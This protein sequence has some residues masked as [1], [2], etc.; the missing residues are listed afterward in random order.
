MGI[1][2]STTW[3]KNWE[4]NSV[5]SQILS[6]GLWYSICMWVFHQKSEKSTIPHHLWKPHPHPTKKCT[7]CQVG[8]GW[9]MFFLFQSLFRAYLFFFF[10]LDFSRA[11][12]IRPCVRI[13]LCPSHSEKSSHFQ[14][15]VSSF[16]ISFSLSLARSN[17]RAAACVAY[18][19]F[20]IPF[21]S[22]CCCQLCSQPAREEGPIYKK[23]LLLLL[24]A[25]CLFSRPRNFQ[26]ACERE[27]ER[28]SMKRR[29]PSGCA[30]ENEVW[31]KTWARA[32]CLSL[33]LWVSSS[34]LFF[35][36]DIMSPA[37]R[38]NWMVP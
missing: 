14:N 4:K 13:S 17:E 8:S 27:K 33:S 16:S 6:R 28:G 12:F 15:A 21:L 26:R 32:V 1:F 22:L 25:V 37:R 36:G 5:P 7:H 30:R 11:V 10:P 24:F 34:W 23:P 35:G 29:P 3:Q 9:K 38:Q 18:R 2:Y 31:H 20:L 19:P